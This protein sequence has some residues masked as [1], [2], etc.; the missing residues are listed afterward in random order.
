[1][2]IRQKQMAAFGE[3]ADAAFIDKVVEYLLE[4]YADVVVHLPGHTALVEELP[5]DS[6]REMVRHGLARARAYRLTWESAL[7]SFIT[8]MFTAAPN[9]DEHPLVR[10]VLLKDEGVPDLRVDLL[11]EHVSAET[12]RV[13][14]EQYDA[15]AWRATPEA[16]SGDA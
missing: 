11:A 2:I 14:R 13:V 5:E 10:R 16:G 15:G 8:Y 3:Q 6:L 1:M 9:F 4:F 12:W 7:A